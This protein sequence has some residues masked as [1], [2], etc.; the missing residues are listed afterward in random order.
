MLEI[1]IAFVIITIKFIVSVII[2]RTLPNTHSNTSV[3]RYF[4]L[5]T[6]KNL[7]IFALVIY[8][9]Q[10]STTLDKELFYIALFVAYI[11]YIPFEL[12]YTRKFFKQ[13][14]KR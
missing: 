9:I 5:I 3:F 8:F 12:N 11:F 7:L 13:D 6:T 4:M 2:I 14:L 10:Q 1:F